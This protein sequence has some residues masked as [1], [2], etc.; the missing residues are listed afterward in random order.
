MDKSERR[1]RTE[2][3]SKKRQVFLR[4]MYRDKSVPARKAGRCKKH[5]PHDCGKSQC[6]VCHCDK[7]D[8]IPTAQEVRSNLDMKEEFE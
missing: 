2:K 3:V 4:K 1:Y 7:I 8:R 5:H 6:Y